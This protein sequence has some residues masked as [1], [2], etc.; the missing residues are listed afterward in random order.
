MKNSREDRWHLHITIIPLER[1]MSLASFEHSHLL[2]R[3]NYI[4]TWDPQPCTTWD[5]KGWGIALTSRGGV[6]V[7]RKG[8]EISPPP[9]PRFRRLCI[10]NREYIHRAFC[11]S[12]KSIHLVSFLS[13][14]KIHKRIYLEHSL[15]S[16]SKHEN[17]IVGSIGKRCMGFIMVRS[18]PPPMIG[19]KMSRAL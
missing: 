10:V 18:S 11:F 6:S 4:N 17:R 14:E 12:F 5:L 7:Q 9:L 8:A 13:F 1:G 15:P 19:E 2:S 16:W 3:D